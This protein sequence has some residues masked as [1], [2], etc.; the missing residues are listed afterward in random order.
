MAE[1]VAAAKPSAF[2]AFDA[3]TGDY[4]YQYPLDQGIMNVVLRLHVDMFAGLWGT[5][6]LG[7]MGLLLGASLVSGVVLYGPFMRKLAF[8]TVRRKQSARLKWL[9]LHNLLGIVTL[10]WFFV[11]GATG[12]INTLA[13]PIFGQWQSGEL[14]EMIA[15]YR[16]RSTA[17]ELGSVQKALDAARMVAPEMSLSFMAFPG[18]G[19][20]GPGHFV[21][22]MQGNSPLTS[23]LLKP[24]LID[25]QTGLVVETRELP[26]YVTALLLS[27]PLH[28]GE[29]GG[30]PLKIILALL[31]ILSIAVL[32]SGLYL[33]LK[34]RNVSLEARP[35][36]L[37]NGSEKQGNSA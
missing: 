22:F 8:G 17:Q 7:F 1:S 20:A 33:W 2:Y 18:N 37:L 30:L 28:F 9:D 27:K 12:V 25:A 4:L 10:V 34:K 13:T 23:K 36:A 31:D 26:W 24:V 14:A 3:R 11:V 15:P 21:A 29:H 35:G 19:F 6:F 5:L 16:D 32:G